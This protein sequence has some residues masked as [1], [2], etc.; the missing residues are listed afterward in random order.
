VADRPT[1]DP[2]LSTRLALQSS[3]ELEKGTAPDRTG[4]TTKLQKR[5]HERRDFE[6]KKGNERNKG[7]QTLV[8]ICDMPTF[9]CLFPFCFCFLRN[10]REGGRLGR[11]R[12]RSL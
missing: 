3:V 5:V 9:V 4:L 8:G 1:L 12:V 10:V 11:P 6:E 2:I 7:S